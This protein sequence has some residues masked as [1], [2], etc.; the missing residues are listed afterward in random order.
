MDL[1]K[2]KKISIVGNSGAGKSTLSKKLGQSLGV[3][4]YSIDRIFWLSGWQL[5][6]Q[7]SFNSLHDQWLKLDSWIIE[8]VGYWS[9]M[10]RRISESDLVIFMDVPI[11]ICK[12][13]AKMRIRE[14][15]TSPNQDITVG[16]VYGDM[17]ERQMEGIE[18][19][20]NKLRPKLVNYLSCFSQGKVRVITSVSELGIN[21]GT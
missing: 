2:A 9:D 21:N 16:C 19:F 6:D 10:E 12:K 17:E 15:K 20:H 4:V 14:E 5:R 13:Q 11:D 3:E 7:G 18:K 1:T 8:G